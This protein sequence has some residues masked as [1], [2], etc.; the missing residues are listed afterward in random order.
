MKAKIEKP[1]RRLD[2][3]KKVF[4][5]IAIVVL[6]LIAVIAFP[7]KEQPI[8]ASQTNTE[9][10]SAL[11]KGGI[12]S[13]NTVEEGDIVKVTYQL[14]EG[15]EKEKAELYILGVLSTLTPNKQKAVVLTFSGDK[16]LGEIEILMEDV[17]KY[18]NKEI[19]LEELKGKIKRL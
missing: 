19:T 18:K 2:R 8:I 11:L 5:A 10:F 1:I 6:V 17:L 12:T 7:K 15:L 9:V 16:K 14:P 3:N 4:V 13:S